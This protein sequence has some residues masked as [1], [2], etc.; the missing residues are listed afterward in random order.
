MV[1]PIMSVII[2]SIFHNQYAVLPFLCKAAFYLGERKMSKDKF[3]TRAE[4]YGISELV[5]WNRHLENL[6]L[7]KDIV[8]IQAKMKL[9]LCLRDNLMDYE[10]PI[11]IEW[12]GWDEKN[13]VIK[14]NKNKR[15][16][17]LIN[18]VTKILDKYY[19]PAQYFG[20]LFYF[21]LTGKQ[22]EGY[23]TKG[24]PSFTYHRD[25][26]G[27]WKHKC[28]ITP[29][30]D[31]E[32]PLILDIIKD[33][34]IARQTKIPLPIKRGKS[35][36]WRPVWEWKKRHPNISDREI[37]DMLHLN[38]VTLSRALEKLNNEYATNKR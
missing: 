5:E 35:K 16:K 13:K 20:S 10:D 32:N 34:Q 27:E 3:W 30:T 8:E 12:M 6:K 26:N 17:K 25:E 29:E 37:A 23:L 9:P 31:L 7:K 22:S 2:N 14:N 19:V 38:R 18:E 28:I 15:R 36:D 11:Y 21:V 4:S 24:F 33:W 1:K